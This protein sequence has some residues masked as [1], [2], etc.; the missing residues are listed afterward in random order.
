MISRRLKPEVRAKIMGLRAWIKTLRK[1]AQLHPR[2]IER[3]ALHEKAVAVAE[4]DINWL[5]TS[6]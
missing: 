6:K 4:W 2:D 3:V 5:E 1:S